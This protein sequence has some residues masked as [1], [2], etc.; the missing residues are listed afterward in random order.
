MRIIIFQKHQNKTGYTI[1]FHNILLHLHIQLSSFIL[2]FPRYTGKKE[3]ILDHSAYFIITQS[4]DGVFEAVPVQAWYNFMPD[5]NYATLDSD[6]V[7]QEFLKRDKRMS[8]YQ[9]KYG[10]G[11]NLMDNDNSDGKVKRRADGSSLVSVLQW[12]ILIIMIFFS[13]FLTLGKSTLS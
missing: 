7:E 11:N 1:L 8:S 6:Q 13:Y 10:F 3:P 2:L 5:I 4:P 12:H 9:E